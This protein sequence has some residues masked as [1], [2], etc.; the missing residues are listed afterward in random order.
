MA[1]E[2]NPLPEAT[3]VT[4]ISDSD[5]E[6]LPKRIRRTDSGSSGSKSGGEDGNTNS[7]SPRIQPCIHWCFTWNNPPGSIGAMVP[8]FHRLL[9]EAA[10]KY[11]YQWE[12]GENGTLHIQGV[13]SFKVK[14]RPM[15]YF[16]DY[17][18][19]HW[20]K[21]RNVSASYAYCSKEDTRLTD[22]SPIVKGYWVCV[23]PS[24][25]GWQKAVVEMMDEMTTRNIYWFWEP[26][27]GVGKTML[28]RYLAMEHQKDL[29]VLGGKAADMK[30]AVATMVEKHGVGPEWVV[31]NQPRSAKDYMSFQGIEEIS[32]G[33]FFNG[34]YESGMICT[35]Q[36][37]ILVFA[38]SPPLKCKDGNDTMSRDRWKV[39]RILSESQEIIKDQ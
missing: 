23:K 2:A 18:E 13:L 11:C 25:R 37:K 16:K 1:Q 21:C 34:K 5:D 38:N 39:F 3:Q 20:E 14:K 29:L 10:T 36:P 19:I 22:T 30:C 28:Q 9:E 15:G 33:I 32:D 8:G 24:I 27:G 6:P 26:T 35:R 7:S 12:R 31:I 17:P 4:E